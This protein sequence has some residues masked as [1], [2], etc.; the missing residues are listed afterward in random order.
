LASCGLLCFTLEQGGIF[1]FRLPSQLDQGAHLAIDDLPTRI[2]SYGSP[3]RPVAALQ[4]VGKLAE[5]AVTNGER[6]LLDRAD[7]VGG[8]RDRRLVLHA[9]TVRTAPA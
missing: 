5:P 6:D 9:S 1:A 2:R 3:P 4:P 7:L 8:C